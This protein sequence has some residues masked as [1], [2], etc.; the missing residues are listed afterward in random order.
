MKLRRRFVGAE[1][2]DLVH[3]VAKIGRDSRGTGSP[4]VAMFDPEDGR[5]WPQKVPTLEVEYRE[6][7][8]Q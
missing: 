4:M 7:Q 6:P 1:L 2:R 8:S 5:R 3:V